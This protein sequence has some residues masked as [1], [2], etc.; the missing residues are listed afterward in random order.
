LIC[1]KWCDHWTRW[2]E[3]WRF[4]I[5]NRLQKNFNKDEYE[6]FIK[7]TSKYLFFDSFDEMFFLK[8]VV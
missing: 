2:N 6:I 5:K 1:K 4:A 3:W 8:C 7:Q